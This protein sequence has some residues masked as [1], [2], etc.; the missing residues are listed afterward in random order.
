MGLAPPRSRNVTNA[1]A[2]FRYFLGQRVPLRCSG[3]AV[4]APRRRTINHLR[5]FKAERWLALNLLYP[6]RDAQ[7]T[8]HVAH[9]RRDPLSGSMCRG[10]FRSILLTG[11]SWSR[12]PAGHPWPA[13][14]ACG[15][16]LSGSMHRGSFLSAQSVAAP[17]DEKSPTHLA[18]VNTSTH[19]LPSA[20]ARV[21]ARWAP[22]AR[23]EWCSLAH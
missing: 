5:A 23:H 2:R 17:P 4:S 16:P 18:G 1:R 9:A 19:W 12:H 21:P 15:A 11:P 20:A 10:D 3:N 14:A 6:L 13:R 8:H 22:G 7:A